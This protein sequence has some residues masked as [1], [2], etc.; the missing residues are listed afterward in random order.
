MLILRPV[1]RGNWATTE[2]S[3][4]GRLGALTFAKGQTIELGGVT[5]RVVRVHA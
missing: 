4:H 2:V 3:I 1:G 5:F